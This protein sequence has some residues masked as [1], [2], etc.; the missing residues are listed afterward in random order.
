MGQPLGDSLPC[1]AMSKRRTSRE[2]GDLGTPRNQAEM[3][4]AHCH[5]DVRCGGERQ[6]SGD[7]MRG[8]ST[9]PKPMLVSASCAPPTCCKVFLMRSRRVPAPAPTRLASRRLGQR[10]ICRHAMSAPLCFSIILSP[11]SKHVMRFRS[12]PPNWPPWGLPRNGGRALGRGLRKTR[13]STQA[14]VTHRTSATHHAQSAH[15]AARPRMCN[16]VQ[17]KARNRS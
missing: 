10:M 7:L 1:N 2:F 4:A 8:E 12:S 13:H 15:L 6:V 16:P 9:S 5:G 11:T 3:P 14:L 17:P